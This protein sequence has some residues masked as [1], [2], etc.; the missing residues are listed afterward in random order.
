[1]AAAQAAEQSRITVSVHKHRVVAHDIVVKSVYEFDSA[2]ARLLRK[3]DN[4]QSL[5][6][7]KPLVGG[8]FVVLA[9]V[10][11]RPETMGM[12][13]CGAGY[14]DYLLLVELHKRTLILRDQFLLQSCLKERVIYGINGERDPIRLMS[15]NVD[16]S[17][18][19]RWES[20]GD[21]QMRMLA[22]NGDRFFTK[23]SP[24]NEN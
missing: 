6:Y 23:L 18:S 17:F 7:E 13:Y 21:G 20:D 9:R 1:M 16:G 10:P 19:F 5:A 3:A 15:R 8:R 11:S 2:A 4:I 14:E 22:V 12:G 24:S